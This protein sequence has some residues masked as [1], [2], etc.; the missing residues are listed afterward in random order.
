MEAYKNW[1]KI[2]ENLENVGL[3]FGVIMLKMYEVLTCSGAGERERE[4]ESS[5]A[6]PRELEEIPPRNGAL[7]QMIF[8]FNEG[9]FV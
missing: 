8:L 3:G 7:V 6:T 2:D 5:M 1:T 4:R 9:W